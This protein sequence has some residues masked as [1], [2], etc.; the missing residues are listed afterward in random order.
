MKKRL[1]Y[2]F[3]CMY[4]LLPFHIQGEEGFSQALKISLTGKIYKNLS[5]TVEEDLRSA[6]DFSQLQWLLGT[7]ELNYK[8][9][10]RIKAGVAYMHLLNLYDNTQHRHRYLLYVTAKQPCG[11]FVF[12]VRERFQSTYAK[13]KKQP[14]SYLRS[15]LTLQY[16]IPKSDFYP[17]VYAETFNNTY[18]GSMALDRM[19]LSAEFTQ[20]DPAVLPISLPICSRS[21]QCATRNWPDFLASVLML[22]SFVHKKTGIPGSHCCYPGIPVTEPKNIY[23][24]LK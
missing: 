14:T 9:H 8:I 21:G 2:L 3:T 6:I 22:L 7:A 11:S 10:P 12:S 18:R 13:H 4:L 20:P 23:Y 5:F 24:F 1:L 15:M 16:H 19:R 17:F